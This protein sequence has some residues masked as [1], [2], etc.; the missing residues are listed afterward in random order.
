MNVS[1]LRLTCVLQFALAGYM[2]VSSFVYIFN[3]PGWHSIVSFVAFGL[4]IYQVSFVLQIIYKNYPD[5]PLS[6][7]QKATF[8]WLFML[9]FFMLSALFTYNINDGRIVTELVKNKQTGL[10]GS[11]FYVMVAL[12]F[13]VTV[14]Q[15]LILLGM[16][17]LRRKL[18][19]N[20]ERKTTDLDILH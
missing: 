9:N 14:F 19:E 1:L 7:T 18:N 8:N 12:H 4:A 16:V 10:V 6:L 13:F 2:A 5:T 20:F 15:L 17:K 11:L 3:A